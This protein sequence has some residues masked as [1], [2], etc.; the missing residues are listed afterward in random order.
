MLDKLDTKLLLLLKELQ[1]LRN[2][3]TVSRQTYLRERILEIAGNPSSD[4][5]ISVCQFVK[6]PGKDK[7]NFT[8]LY[9][10]LG[11]QANR[12]VYQGRPSIWI[13]NVNL[14]AIKDELE[15]RGEINE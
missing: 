12:Y 3:S 15:R 2:N 7:C 1:E 6:H 13:Q 8:K 9:E 4:L 10:E 14:P 11:P 5:D